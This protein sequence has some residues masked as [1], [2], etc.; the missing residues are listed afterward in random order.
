MRYNWDLDGSILPMLS[1]QPP[2]NGDPQSLCRR[3]RAR[4]QHR[5]HAD[6]RRS[7]AHRQ[8]AGAAAR[9]CGRLLLCEVG[10]RWLQRLRLLQCRDPGSRWRLEIDNTST[11][12]YAQGTLHLGLLSD[13]LQRFRFTAGIRRTEDEIEGARFS[14]YYSDRVYFGP[15]Q[16][17]YD[18][19]ARRA[20]LNSDEPTWTIGLDYEASDSMLLYG[21]VSRGY[22]AGAFNAIAPRKLTAEP[23]FVTSYEL[24]AKTD[25]M[26]GDVPARVNASL[27]LP[28]L[29]GYPA[30][31]RRQLRRRFLPA[32]GVRPQRQRFH[33]YWRLS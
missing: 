5:H 25:F 17:D 24:G 26:I 30:L 10:A 27:F 3:G 14:T 11:A 20:E 29:R 8:L 22:K 16:N 32:G 9:L 15:G 7:A 6:N 2:V 4:Q 13:T 31:G 19:P 21:K 1:Q 33:R 28:R 12:F 18:L 23:E